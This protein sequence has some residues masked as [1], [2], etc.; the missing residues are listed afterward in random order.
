VGTYEEWGLICSMKKVGKTGEV[1]CS[2]IYFEVSF[3][4]TSHANV[5]FGCRLAKVLFT[6]PTGISFEF[7]QL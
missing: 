4:I 2:Y 6:K 5:L 3:E 1:H 7:I